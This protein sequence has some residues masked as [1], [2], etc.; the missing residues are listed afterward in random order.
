L[1]E[2]GCSDVRAQA[3]VVARIEGTDKTA[4]CREYQDSVDL[5]AYV[6]SDGGESSVL[7]LRSFS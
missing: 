2:V 3:K 5:E 1:V 6:D 4:E 7:C